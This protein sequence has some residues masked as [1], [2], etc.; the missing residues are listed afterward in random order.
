MAGL[1]LHRPGGAWTDEAD[2]I[3]RGRNGL[4]FGLQ[5]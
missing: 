4:P 2:A 3:L 5:Q 1:V